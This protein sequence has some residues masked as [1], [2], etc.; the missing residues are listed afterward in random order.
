MQ[1]AVVHLLSHLNASPFTQARHAGTAA[2][3][4]VDL[5]HLH[6]ALLVA[7]V[8]DEPVESIFWLEPSSN[9]DKETFQ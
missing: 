6:L 3:V 5:G 1:V 8:L 9:D 7:K 4:R 2:V